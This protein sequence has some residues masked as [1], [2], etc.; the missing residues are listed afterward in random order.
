LV[1]PRQSLR[2]LHVDDDEMIL[3]F[4]KQFVA[5]Q[6]PSLQFTTTTSPS[7]ALDLLHAQ[8]YD[9]VLLD[10]KM[11]E[12][13]GIELAQRIR[14]DNKTPI[15]LYT[16]QGSEE[17]AEQ[18]Y[19]AGIDD[20]I[21]KEAH[22]AHYQVLARR[23]RHVIEKHRSDELYR[24]VVE[25]C[26]D[27]C[28]ISRENTFI[29]TN[30][31]LANIFGFNE[32][33]EINGK[34]YLQWLIEEDRQTIINRNRRFEGG[35][36]ETEIINYR[37][38]KPS[39]V[40]RFIE[41]HGRRVIFEGAPATLA[42]TRDVT[43][44]KMM[45]NRLKASEERYR[46]SFESITD[47]IHV[48]DSN[49]QIV[50]TNESLRR[51]YAS[52]GQSGDPIG[53]NL[54]EAFPFFTETQ[55]SEY[56]RVFET[57]QPIIT[58]EAQKFDG[59][60]FFVEIKKIPLHEGEKVTRILTVIRDV[61]Q[62][63]TLEA[64]LTKSSDDQRTVSNRLHSFMDSTPESIV[65]Y[66][67]NLNAVDFNEAWLKNHEITRDKATG[68]NIRQVNPPP[69]EERVQKYIKV[70]E[71]GEPLSLET[72]VHTPRGDV[73]EKIIR[74]FKVGEGVGV[75][76]IDVTEM[77]RMA[78]AVK[79][80][81]EKHRLVSE[82]A[83]D[84][85]F[86]FSFK[87]G[88]EYIN[89]A[90][91]SMLGYTPEELY[92][93]PNALY[94]FTLPE[95]AERIQI[96]IQ[97]MATGQF[98]NDRPRFN[99]RHKDGHLI[100][101]E[102]TFQPVLGEDGKIEAIEGVARDISQTV[103][104]EKKLEAL[105]RHST[106]I[107][108]AGNIE[109]ISKAT[110]DTIE[111]II[112]IHLAAFM[113]KHE[114]GLVSLENRLS[115]PLGRS[116]P[117]DGKGITA[118]T[119]RE[120]RTIRV[121]DV[122][123]DPDYVQSSSATLSE[124]AVPVVLD[125]E[126]IAVLNLESQETNKFTDEDQSLVE[127]LAEH[128][129][130]AIKK[131]R[132]I[133][134]ERD[135]SK[136]LE[137]LHHHAVQL[138]S[139]DNL[140][141]IAKFTL[142]TVDSVLGHG[143]GGF[144]VVEDEKL[145]FLYSIGIDLSRIAIIPLD[146]KGMT[147]RTARL[148]VTQ[149]AP[150]VRLDPDYFPDGDGT[151]QSELDVP[152]KID[153][154]TIA[155]INLESK[156]LDAYTPEDRRMVE[157]L[158]EHVALAIKRLNLLAKERRNAEKLE[159]L[160]NHAL[161]LNELTTLKEI[162]VF[163]LEII[164]EVLGHTQTLF[165]MINGEKLDLIHVMGVS[166][167]VIPEIRLDSPSIIVKAVKT[168]KTQMVLDTRLDPDYLP[169]KD[170]SNLSELDVPIKV[171]GK[172]VGVINLET[173]KP[174]AYT[175]DD[176]HIS[177]I[178]C[179]HVALA[180][181]RL[182]LLENERNNAENLEVLNRSA[183]HLD[184]SKNITEA[185]DSAC[186][187]LNEDFGYSF[188]GIGRVDEDAIRYVK[189]VGADLSGNDVIP[190]T[191]NTVTVRAVESGETQL[192]RDATKDPDYIPLVPI[193]KPYLSELVVPVKVRGRIEYVLNLESVELDGFTDE[194]R[195][196]IEL[197]ALHL[198][199]A[200]Q[201][202]RERERLAALHKHAPLIARAK[203]INE[204]AKLVLTTADAVFHFPIA[205]L[206]VVRGSVV[207]LIY[208][209]DFT[210]NGSFTQT[211]DGPGL[212]PY[213]I[214]EGK[215]LLIDDVRQNEHYVRGPI[216]N[217]VRLSELVVPVKLRD[218]VV[219][220]INLENSRLAAFN[221]EDRRMAELLALHVG[222]AME[223]IEEKKQIQE[224]QMAETRELLEGANRISSM[225]RHDLRGPLQSIKNATFL[226]EQ[227]PEKAKEM[228]DAI[229]KSVDYATKILDDL[230][231]STSPIKLAKA[232]TNVNDLVEQSI[233]SASIPGDINVHRSYSEGFIAASLDSTRIRRAM[234]NLIKNAVEA[235]P[236]G[237]DLTVTVKKEGETVVID[238][239][240]TGVGIPPEVMESLFRP[241]FTTKPR[242][243]GLGLAVCRQAVE[244]H[245]GTITLSSEQGKGTTFTIRLPLK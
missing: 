102:L 54:M 245:G 167:D 12:M 101:L 7:A 24:T 43:E 182:R 82:N 89:K 186:K 205:G 233:A 66:D 112:G 132:L 93:S 218:K 74:V 84:L 156:T 187:I 62:Q 44:T 188:V 136:K 162:A 47:A 72:Q 196:Q 223:L 144:A 193:E 61:T 178:L 201:L 77:K 30:Q 181:K 14:V 183:A 158:C 23:I 229:D 29:Y 189:Y 154:K 116:L 15:I 103:A 215:S 135:S 36:S 197:L 21:R 230:R 100:P 199:S 26:P 51:L 46:L 110:L 65:I 180:I 242:G 35:Q 122:R 207:E 68:I 107:A 125:G 105:H 169:D 41:S 171:D 1:A 219:A 206:H 4:V 133:E 31:V 80:S 119:A 239:A 177:E 115:P 118:K 147:A 208:V 149:Y 225:V 185:I 211:I 170:K 220:V 214:R 166:P 224:Q 212:I 83:R 195:R 16:G 91:E 127:I 3:D 163:T 145:E 98:T 13:T 159:A 19:A 240:D 6:D 190:F 67:K 18:A 69:Y 140:R 150:D 226:A 8:T 38:R 160:H 141:D 113:I 191:W 99:G 49:Y 53:R 216:G 148:G 40:V 20:Y 143:Y 157:V 146:G 39:G 42:F 121:R 137:A 126:T 86:R 243:T 131:L 184:Q 34:N 79:A 48:I 59:V 244:A 155:I 108:L 164:S 138:S 202:I 109:E 238:V 45:E 234:D 5:G 194:A 217:D 204:I 221:E 95:D 142:E 94:T 10:Y 152:I 58:E 57:G 173:P 174:H 172:V 78:D 104:Y 228:L 231:N 232:V 64:E 81:E 235:M 11:P 192:V 70:I 85:I 129:S 200:L 111:E 120:Q 139:L 134:S 37:L 63:R 114:D 50:L 210:E 87:T 92:A 106:A 97:Q 56:R 124:L 236:R 203:D 90:V 96:L 25:S 73:R 60:D 222:T 27:G 117:L 175:N 88:F 17:V 165:T 128:I 130:S 241:F 75:I 161:K 209:P 9:C 52:I 213:A 55:R 32:P 33:A 151:T 176:R 168:G 179:E 22:P 76:S 237:G 198:S 71:T 227:Q 28:S 153:G 2:V 123:L